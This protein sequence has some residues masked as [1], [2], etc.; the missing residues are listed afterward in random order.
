[1]PIKDAFLALQ[2]VRE[3]KRSTFL[4][5]T[6]ESIFI[7]LFNDTFNYKKNQRSCLKIL[8]EGNS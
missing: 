4:N 6:L 3:K 1:M 5:S 8:G 7:Y 2:R